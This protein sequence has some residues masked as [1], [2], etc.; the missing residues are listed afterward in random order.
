LIE[1]LKSELSDSE[2]ALGGSIDALTA[3]G[4]RQAQ[5]LEVLRDQLLASQGTT[6]SL[7]TRLQDFQTCLELISE[8]QRT[9]N[10]RSRELLDSM[11]DQNT[12]L[13]G[14]QKRLT[15]ATITTCVIAGLTLITAVFIVLQAG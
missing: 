12:R 15:T 5:T 11:H 6:E 7:V 14:Q 3:T 9:T 10:D 2:R 8:Q 13:A 1:T 4:D